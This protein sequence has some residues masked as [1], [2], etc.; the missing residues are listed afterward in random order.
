MNKNISK[1]PISKA[2]LLAER[3][4]LSKIEIENIRKEK[5]PTFSSRPKFNNMN[6]NI[7]KNPISKAKFVEGPIKVLNDLEVYE[8]RKDLCRV[9]GGFSR[10][11]R[12]VATVIVDLLATH[13]DAYFS[14]SLVATRSHCCLRTVCRVLDKLCD[15]G[16]IRKVYR[17]R[18]ANRWRT[19]VYEVGETLY[20][21]E[22]R[23]MLS[24]VLPVLSVTAIALRIFQRVSRCILKLALVSRISI[25][26]TQ[27]YN[28]LIYNYKNIQKGKISLGVLP[29]IH[30]PAHNE[31]EQ[32]LKDEAFYRKRSWE[33]GKMKSEAMEKAKAEGRA[34]LSWQRTM[35]E[36]HRDKETR[37]AIA[38]E[39]LKKKIDTYN[40]I[41][42]MSG[43]NESAKIVAR[44]LNPFGS[45]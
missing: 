44:A 31:R 43:S 17:C 28:K 15:L 29:Q 10:C 42:E 5:Q 2:K 14:Q 34:R 24:E 22:T 32:S 39:P 30:S 37:E 6:K 23:R 18:A 45:D 4:V 9:V 16:L 38:N 36:C 33:R 3:E 20:D 27:E 7:A 40:K 13:K 19:C 11:E 25:N 21:P 41:N 26:V 35:E 8:N 12:S 1:N